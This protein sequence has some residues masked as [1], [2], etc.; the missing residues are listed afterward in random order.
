[1]RGKERGPNTIYVI[2]AEGI[3]VAHL[4]DLGHTIGAIEKKELGDIDVLL[5]PVGG[6]FTIEPEEAWEVVKLL[7]PRIVIP[8]H[9][10]TPSV[11]F[12]LAPVEE[13]TKGK[14]RV[15]MKDSQVEISLPPQNEVWVLKPSR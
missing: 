13:F 14:E 12:P 8:M 5:T 2:E 4:G 10:K 3:R 6:V 7:D 15:L 11:T 9:F 1:M